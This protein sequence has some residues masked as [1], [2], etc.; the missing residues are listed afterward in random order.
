MIE[1]WQLINSVLQMVHGEWVRRH[2]VQLAEEM[3]QLLVESKADDV[4]G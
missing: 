2:I 1:A 4:H 3:K